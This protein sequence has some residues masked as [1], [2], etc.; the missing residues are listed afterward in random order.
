[1]NTPI[2]AASPLTAEPEAQAV[3]A[4]R[5]TARQEQLAVLRDRVRDGTSCGI[6]GDRFTTPNST[7]LLPCAHTVHVGCAKDEQQHGRALSCR[8]C[9]TVARGVTTAL[10]VDKLPASLQVDARLAVRVPCTA[11][12][13]DDD[14]DESER[15][16]ATYRCNTCHVETNLCA[17][18]AGVHQTKK[19]TREHAVTPLAGAVGEAQTRTAAGT[20]M[21]LLCRLHPGRHLELYC[22]QCKRACCALCA[23]SECKKHDTPTIEDELPLLKKTLQSQ[24]LAAAQ[25][26]AQVE[27]W[28]ADVALVQAGVNEQQETLKSQM[29]T[30]FAGLRA[31]LDRNEAAL[32]TQIDTHAQTQ[33]TAITKVQDE[34]RLLWLTVHQAAAM[35]AYLQS[36]SVGPSSVAAVAGALT[37]H[38]QT[39]TRAPLPQMPKVQE[40]NVE[41]VP[42]DLDRLLKDAVRLTRA[43]VAPTDRASSRPATEERTPTHIHYLEDTR[44]ADNVSIFADDF[45]VES[46]AEMEVLDWN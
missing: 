29:R 43:A 37:T 30:I 28:L 4:Q 35:M 7:V 44:F 46:P 34:G 3:A 12:A 38:V 14:I 16:L 20:G 42:A 17:I 32:T 2:R 11:C 21:L 6:C 15:K 33:T 13:T 25:Y 31:L 1:M 8:E 39:A 26:Q 40:A 36:E 5:E 22:R 41:A 23:A 10:D 24:H 27:L 19:S 9:G 18:H 45:A